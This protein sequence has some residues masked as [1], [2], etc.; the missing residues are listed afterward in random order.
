MSRTKIDDRKL[1]RYTKGEEIF[2]SVSHIVGSG[3]GLVVLILCTVF[4]ALH[5]NWWGLFSGIFYGLMMVFLY[6]VSSVYHGVKRSRM[7]KILQVVD[8]CSI[9]ALIVGTYAPVLSTGMREYNPRLTLIITILVTAGTII[10]VVFTAI[11]FHKYVVISY[12]SYF[13]IGWSMLFSIREVYKAFGNEFVFWLVLGGIIY[14]LGMIFFGLSAKNP[15]KHEYCH[16]IFH[17]FIVAGSVLQF[18]GIFRFCICR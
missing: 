12:A 10:G 3:F 13:V 17:L 15:K 16:S 2:N 4:S 14:T 5:K 11:D 6:T 9:F 7:K 8:H 18:V 1:P